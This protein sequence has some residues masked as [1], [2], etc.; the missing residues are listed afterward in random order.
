MVF[1]ISDNSDDSFGAPLME[2]SRFLYAFNKSSEDHRIS[3]DL[4]RMQFGRPG[5]LLPTAALLHRHSERGGDTTVKVPANSKCLEYLQNIS[6]PG[7]SETAQLNSKVNIRENS[8]SIPIVQI[9]ANENGTTVETDAMHSIYRILQNHCSVIGDLQNACAYLI[10]EALTNISDHSDA[11]KGWLHAQFYPHKRFL[12]ICIVD[13]GKTILGSYQGANFDEVMDDETAVTKAI[14]GQSVKESD[15]GRGMG[16]STSRR[17][18][19]EGMK[20]QHMIL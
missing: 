14:S 2:L 5:F 7:I 13:L 8:I 4:S 18:I 10:S 11:S 19:A 6:F 15:G 9:S 1:T 12:E 20:G 16:I 3:I 17:M